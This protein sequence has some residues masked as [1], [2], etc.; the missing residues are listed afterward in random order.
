MKYKLHLSDGVPGET[1]HVIWWEV[2]VYPG[3]FPVYTQQN[4]TI[5]G[6]NDPVN[7]VDGSVH[8]VDVPSGECSIYE[9]APTF[10]P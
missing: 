5:T 4:E 7:G 2:T 8:A 9:T 3:G 6:S 1:Y 10:A